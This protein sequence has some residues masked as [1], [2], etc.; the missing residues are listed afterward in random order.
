MGHSTVKTRAKVCGITSVNDAKMTQSAGADALG[1]VFYEPSPRNVSIDLAKEIAYS[2]GPFIS[3]VGLFVNASSD[4]VNQV[5]DSV[6]LHLL[7][8]HG[9]ESV[10]ECE[11]YHRPYIKAIRMKDDVDI[12]QSIS[13]YVSASGFLLD[14]YRKGIPGG[15][16][17]IF[18]W[19][20]VPQNAEKP[21][22]V[23][24]GLTPDNV[25]EAIT[26]TLPYG[27][28]VSGGVELSPGVKDAKKVQEFIANVL[29]V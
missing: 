23:A 6:P 29:S 1:L 12:H 25:S 19:D 14:T 11:Q 8:F 18:D 24:G 2:V 22:I 13:E 16:G 21:I 7:Q 10:R 3:L 27:V 17:E 9:D 20:K 4:Y 5:L 28:D 15:T 26:Q